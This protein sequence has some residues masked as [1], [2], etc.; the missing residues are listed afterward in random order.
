MLDKYF[1]VTFSDDHSKT[2]NNWPI[3]FTTNYFPLQILTCRN[4]AVKVV[5]IVVR[6]SLVDD[7]EEKL[8]G[9]PPE[10][11]VETEGG[12][13]GDVAPTIRVLELI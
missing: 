8:P 5:S 12:T 2:N 6:F 1:I 4:T 13:N 3:S 7:P 9:D 11:V 10:N